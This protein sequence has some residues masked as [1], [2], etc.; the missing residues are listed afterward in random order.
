[1]FVHCIAPRRCRPTCRALTP[2]ALVVLALGVSSGARAELTVLDTVTVSGAQAPD[3]A[4]HYV[5]PSTRISAADAEQVNTSSAED[6]FKYQPSLVIRRRYIGDSNGTVGMR[7]ANMFQTARTMVFADGLPLHS[8]LETRWNG[9]PRWGL[10]AADEIQSAEVIY[11]PFSA[12]HSG[13][14]MGG[15]VNIKTRLPTTREVHAEAAL[16]SQP[17]THLGADETYS[18]HREYLSFGDRFGDL[19]LSVFHNHLENT[20]QPQTF[21]ARSILAPGAGTAIA[22][23]AI[24]GKDSVSSDVIYVGDS[25]PASTQTDLTKFKLGYTVGEWLTTATVAYEERRWRTRPTNYLRDAAGNAVWSGN[26]IWNGD[27]FSISSGHFAVSNQERETLLVGLGLEGPLGASGWLLETTLSHF[28]VLRD[29]T[30]TSDRNP[31]DPAFTPAGSV[32]DYEDTGWLTLDIKARTRN[33]LG[34]DDLRL[35]TGYH[36]E[37]NSLT[38][39][40]WDSTDFAAGAK[41]VSDT[42]TGGMSDFYGDCPSNMDGECFGAEVCLDFNNSD[43]HVCSIAGCT[44]VDDCEA[45]DGF[46]VQCKSNFDK[47]N[48]N[49]CVINCKGMMGMELDCPVDMVCTS[50]NMG[51]AKICTWPAP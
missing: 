41:S 46:D 1:M 45:Y 11:G 34:R 3:S 5:S 44:N 37:R 16:F 47:Y 40:S 36:Y 23:G 24:K 8:M 25:G 17:F 30:R 15:V 27:R 10:V 28:D 18:G 21:R 7:G 33:F 42:T 35:L 19:Q 20:G 13:N 43:T 6:L 39:K 48:S 32:T 50:F 31:A 29:Q 22:S 51:A 9:A 12:E 14:A 38:K 26:A 4:T 49:Y 2:L